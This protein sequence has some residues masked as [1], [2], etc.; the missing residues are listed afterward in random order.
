MLCFV[1]LSE[2]ISFSVASPVRHPL[3]CSSDT[4][5]MAQRQIQRFARS[6]SQF[7]AEVRTVVLQGCSYLSWGFFHVNKMFDDLHTIKLTTPLSTYVLKKPIIP[8]Q[9]EKYL[10][11]YRQNKFITAF[12]KANHCSISRANESSLD[13]PPHSTYLRS[14]LILSFNLQPDHPDHKIRWVFSPNPLSIYISLHACHTFRPSHSHSVFH[15]IYAFPWHK[16]RSSA[17]F[18]FFSASCPFLFLQY[19]YF[20]HPVALLYLK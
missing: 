3:W 1:F 2:Q 8:E 10:A 16:S 9:F 11:F 7:E 19:K 13:S 17:L 5:G 12:K 6:A 18:N 20:L 4:N 15:R 14:I